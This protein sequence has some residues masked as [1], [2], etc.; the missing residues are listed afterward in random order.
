MNAINCTRMGSN[1]CKRVSFFV[2]I[3]RSSVISSRII[4]DFSSDFFIQLLSR[5][6]SLLFEYKRLLEVQG[7]DGRVVNAS[8]EV[9]ESDSSGWGS[10]PTFV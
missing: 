7:T 5:R 4:L 10:S 2:Q 8:V 3:V 6:N 1:Y 9:K